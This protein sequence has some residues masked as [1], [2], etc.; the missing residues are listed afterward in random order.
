MLAS[1]FGTIKPP[2]DSILKTGNLIQFLSLFVRLIFTL[3]G[4]LVFINFILAGFQYI[5]AAGDPQKIAQASK[6]MMNS[7][8]GLTIIAASFLIAAFIGY[9]LF[10]DASALLKPQFYQVNP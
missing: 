6:K 2:D 3:A 7:L 8:M 4:L 10:Q 5:F 1:T 9:L